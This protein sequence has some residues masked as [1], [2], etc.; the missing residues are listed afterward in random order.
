VGYH[1]WLLWLSVSDVS[2]GGCH[3]KATIKGSGFLGHDGITAPA[4]SKYI[5]AMSTLCKVVYH[6]ATQKWKG[7]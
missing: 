2:D 6:V 4:R 3:I 5:A 7:I 1:I